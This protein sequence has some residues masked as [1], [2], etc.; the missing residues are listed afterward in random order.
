MNPHHQQP[1]Q[2]GHSLATQSVLWVQT[3]SLLCCWLAA[4]HFLISDWVL[5]FQHAP[6]DGTITRAF[7]ESVLVVWVHPL[8]FD[9]KPKCTE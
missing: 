3:V 6:T 1:L 4:V 9:S 7:T 5:P 8:L 2:S